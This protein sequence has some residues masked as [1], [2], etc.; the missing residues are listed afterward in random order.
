MTPKF[1]QTYTDEV[2]KQLD[3]LPTWPL[4]YDVRLGDVGVLEGNVFKRTDTLEVLGIDGLAVESDGVG[5]EASRAQR[6]DQIDDPLQARV[7]LAPAHRIRPIWIPWLPGESLSATTNYRRFHDHSVPA[8]I[9]V[10]A[11]PRC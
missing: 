2:S 11:T 3:Y 8:S 10:S 5:G 6:E 4:S 7:L 9:V 1:V